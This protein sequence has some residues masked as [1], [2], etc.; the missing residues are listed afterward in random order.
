MFNVFCVHLWENRASPTLFFSE[1][2]L[3]T[4]W[5]CR[6]NRNSEEL[7]KWC[8]TLEVNVF[9][10]NIHPVTQ[11]TVCLARWES[12][13]TGS[14]NAAFHSLLRSIGGS[15]VWAQLAE[16]WISLIAG[17]IKKAAPFPC[18]VLSW[19]PKR[20]RMI[21]ETK[22]GAALTD[23]WQCPRRGKQNPVC[24]FTVSSLCQSLCHLSVMS[25]QLICWQNA[26]PS[27]TPFTFS[28]KF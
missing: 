26:F 22:L 4:L 15:S 7:C 17:V 11:H 3:F 9:C 24:D 16:S 21:V 18:Q 14:T 19:R 13:K 1:L 6:I 12:H 5:I 8:L 2:I 28:F 27:S 10:P 23:V 20:S 25:L